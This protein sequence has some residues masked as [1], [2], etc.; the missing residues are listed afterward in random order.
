MG[1]GQVKP[2]EREWQGDAPESKGGAPWE[3]DWQQSSGPT[4]RQKTLSN[5]GSRFLRGMTDPI[6]AGA[7]LLTHALPE[8]LVNAVNSGAQFVNDLPGIGPLT[9]ALG[10]T[11]A[12]SGGLDKRIREGEQEYQAARQA[13]APA[14]LSS[15]VSGQRNPGFDLARAFGNVATGFAVPGG[16]AAGMGARILQGAGAGAASGALQPV[17]ED[18]DNFW[19]EKGKQ[20]LV[21]GATGAAVAPIVGALARVIRPN[22]SKAART[23]LDEGVTPTPGQILGGAY[24]TTE[25]KITSLPLIGDAI[26]SARKKSLDELNRAVYQRALTPIGQKADDLPVGRE[27]VARVHQQLQ[28]AY[29]TLLPNLSFKADQPFT[30]AVATVRGMVRRLPQQIKG[31]LEDIYRDKVVSR[32]TPQGLMNGRS[33]KDAESDLGQE[34]RRLSKDPNRHAQQLKD[35]VIELRDQMRQALTRSNPA[36]AA[37]LQAIN[38]GY[39]NFAR[40]RDAGAALGDKSGG[41]TPADLLGAV[42]RNDHSVGKGQFATGRAQMQDLADAAVATLPGK[43]PDSGTTGRV[44]LGGMATGA[45][46]GA[47]YFG[48]P[49]IPIAAAAGALPYMPGGRQLAAALLARRGAMADPMAQ[50]L[51]NATPKIAAS[52]APLVYQ[53]S[54]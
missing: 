48:N 1:A 17:V 8:G 2:W 29:N 10:M 20:T 30:Q 47:G 52:I 42:R 51:R 23:L 18:Q 38:Q 16:N 44:L 3:R 5:A 11:P 54:E 21:G 32:M 27:G 7:Q 39:S 14:T 41:F 6:D 35:A 33:F 50:S 49:L 12:T 31:E 37:E 36:H 25:D 13:T 15:L 53:P 40:I 26:T 9:K 4:D 43:Y 46:G 45:L 28:D 34:I 22:T 19:S 24:R